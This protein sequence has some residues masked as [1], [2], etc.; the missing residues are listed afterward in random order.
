M[1]RRKPFGSMALPFAPG[2][3]TVAPRRALAV[4]VG[5]LVLLLL[6]GRLWWLPAHAPLDVNE[7]WNAMQAMRAF[8]PGSLYPP[9]D[10]LTANNYPPL[11]FFL[12]GGVGRLTGDNV[13]A[14][15]LVSL[16][17]EAL[18][19]AAVLVAA[20]RL[21]RG[22]VWG[23][24]G[25]GIFAGFAVTL[26]RPYAVMNDPQWIAEA[27]MLWA[28]VLLLP[29]SP[30]RRLRRGAVAFSALLVVA[31]LLTKH[32]AVVLPAVMF[33][34]LWR[35]ERAALLRWCLTGLGLAVLA[36][37][38]MLLLW[39]TAPFVG[40]LGAARSY[41]LSR[42]VLKGGPT[43]LALLPGLLAC[44]PLW[45]RRRDP[46]GFV[47]ILL[48]LF[49]VPVALI[50]RSGDGVDVNAAFEAVIA[51]AVA[52]PVAC[53]TRPEGAGRRVLLAVLPVLCLLP[54]AMRDN[55]GE[56]SGR[57]AA[58]RRWA[59][60][61]ARV[62]A[63]TGPVACDDQVV[64]YWAGRDAGLDVFLLKQRLLKGPDPALEAA[65]AARRFAIIELRTDDTSWHAD[66][67]RPLILRYYVPA[68]AAGGVAL[69]VPAGAAAGPTPAC[70]PA[71]ASPGGP[72]ADACVA[73]STPDHP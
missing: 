56:L 4:V 64:C 30:D 48:L 52:L 24:L 18:A 41:S 19:A 8:G 37:G 2:G 15:R 17:A 22:R 20:G 54:F 16:L 31:G 59:D 66:L 5:L 45:R 35:T 33:L 47:S 21:A 60:L 44:A 61:V 65:L 38:A 70:G 29:A 32:N 72:P 23:W 13:V 57:D 68:Y 39:G 7:G 11:S 51:L 3:G 9:P 36:G 55:L 69:L 50:Q 28:F 6:L 62:A 40:I 43:L 14:G 53:A 63:A 67:L 58:V 46:A 12:V 49:S 26:L 42:M 27:A 10:A 1:M 73:G 71:R 25:L 34:W